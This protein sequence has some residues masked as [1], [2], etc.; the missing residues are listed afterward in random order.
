[1]MGSEIS[2]LGR[3]AWCGTEQRD[4]SHL[5]SDARQCSQTASSQGIIESPK[6]ASQIAAH[7]KV[8]IGDELRLPFAEVIREQN[9]DLL[10]TSSDD[11]FALSGLAVLIRPA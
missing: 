7:S 1:M 3:K 8:L 4:E 2:N 9:M 11:H 5:Y 6:T 10:N